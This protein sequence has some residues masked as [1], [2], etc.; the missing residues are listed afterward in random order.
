MN[1]PENQVRVCI[2]TL[3]IFDIGLE[4]E[5]RRKQESKFHQSSSVDFRLNFHFRF[6]TYKTPFMTYLQIAPYYVSFYCSDLL[7][8]KEF[9]LARDLMNER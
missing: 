4:K 8:C 1:P 2:V 9:N 3:Q 5:T 7:S 6:E